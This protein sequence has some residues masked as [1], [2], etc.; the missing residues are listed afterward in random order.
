[1]IEL[2]FSFPISGSMINLFNVLLW[3]VVGGVV[4]IFMWWFR[5]EQTKPKIIIK[6]LQRQGHARK[7]IKEFKIVYDKE[8]FN[9]R[10]R[11][12]LV[13]VKNA[14]Y[15]NSSEPVLYF[16]VDKFAP[17]EPVS[18]ETEDNNKTAAAMHFLFGRKMVE[19]GLAA[20]RKQQFGFNWILALVAGI[21]IG[22]MAGIIIF[23]QFF[24]NMFTTPAPPTPPYTPPVIPPP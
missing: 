6:L 4:I 8:S 15:W 22:M 2:P 12:Y 20:T 10:E 7:L 5:R 18:G 9:F 21:A 16:D 11:T 23:P 19:A 17:I 13:N 3:G 1:M 14:Q 24:P